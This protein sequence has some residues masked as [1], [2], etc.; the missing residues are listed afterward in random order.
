MYERSV[1]DELKKNVL[2]QD[3]VS[4]DTDLKEVGN[5]LIGSC[6]MPEHKDS[7]PS[8]NIYKETNTYFCH[9]CKCTGDVFKYLTERDKIGFVKAVEE[10]AKIAGK[11]IVKQ[12]NFKPKRETYELEVV[13][14]IIAEE[15]H[16]NLMNAPK[17]V[18][19]Y[20]RERG[21][22]RESVKKYYLG[23]ASK[24]WNQV[25]GALKKRGV[26]KKLAIESG[27][28]VEN[29]RGG[30]RDVFRSR[31]MFPVIDQHNRVIGFAGRTIPHY[32]EHS[33]KYMNTKKTP[34]YSKG[35]VL[36]GMHLAHEQ[37][38]KNNKVYIV[39]GYMD[40]I[41]MR[42]AGI[43][44]TV[45]IGGTSYTN[46]HFRQLSKLATQ[47]VLLLDGDHGG[48]KALEN[49]YE[50]VVDSEL[51]LT[52]KLL[53]SGED[54]DTFI[55]K[56][57]KEHEEEIDKLPET[58][59]LDLHIEKIQEKLNVKDITKA[60]PNTLAR[61]SQNI[62]KEIGRIADNQNRAIHLS[63][64]YSKLKIKQYVESQEK[65]YE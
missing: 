39:E 59:P 30:L 8:F 31:L 14:K 18:K 16:N 41:T 47:G 12:K 50:K 15:Y 34:L 23:F 35:E 7:N 40:A 9:G 2:L 32:Y 65:S 20:L 48:K 57:D 56:F 62:E 61:I 10:V 33:S 5:K 11:S 21:I 3:I 25:V 17:V 52:I 19:D 13:N 46:A 36:Y 24:D 22:A 54:P 58:T 28:V 42:Q 43:Y 38:K 64:L 51:D 1:I 6:P 63:R 55:S 26:S 37:I 49:I 27:T 53:P 29:D 60:G 44:N 45:A 4:K